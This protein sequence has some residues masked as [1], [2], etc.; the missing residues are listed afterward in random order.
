MK[1]LHNPSLEGSVNQWALGGKKKILI[2]RII[3][4][5]CVFSCTNLH[6]CCG[7]C[8]QGS[9]GA[10]SM[11]VKPLTAPAAHIAEEGVL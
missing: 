8:F 10:S 6:C 11:L 1:S 3:I 2:L 9:Q 4:L 7:I 5:I